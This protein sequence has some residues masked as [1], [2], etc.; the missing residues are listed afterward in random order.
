MHPGGFV[1][2]KVV[3]CLVCLAL[4][5]C[6]STSPASKELAATLIFVQG[7]QPLDKLGGIYTVGDYALPR[8]PSREVHLAPGNRNI[9]YSCPGYI[10]VD[11][12][13][14][15]WH[16]FEGGVTYEMSCEKGVP[17]FRV[18]R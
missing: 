18:M 1:I 5:A 10:F 13:P 15:I 6:A 9:G 8:E 3:A 16:K 7:D 4:V 14:S 12:P 2:G 11:N 17:T